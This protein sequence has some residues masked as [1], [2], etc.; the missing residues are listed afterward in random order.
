MPLFLLDK[1]KNTKE[2][3]EKGEQ[4]FGSHY[5]DRC[6]IYIYPHIHIYDW[7]ILFPKE[8]QPAWQRPSMS[9]QLTNCVL[10]HSHLQNIHRYVDKY[11]TDQKDTYISNGH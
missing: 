2:K 3:E 11:N 9:W 6:Y 1:T 8:I 5:I 7:K 4:Q 10:F